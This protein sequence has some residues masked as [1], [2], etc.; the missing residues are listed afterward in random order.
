MYSF[1]CLLLLRCVDRVIGGDRGL[2]RHCKRAGHRRV[3]RLHPSTGVPLPLRTLRQR[4][5]DRYRV[6]M[7]CLSSRKSPHSGLPCTINCDLSHFSSP[8]VVWLAT[9][10]TLSPLPPWITW[11]SARSFP[12]FRW[13]LQMEWMSLSAGWFA[14]F[15]CFMYGFFNTGAVITDLADR[16]QFNQLFFVACF[17]CQTLKWKS[18]GKVTCALLFTAIK[19][20]ETAMTTTLR[21]SS[22]LF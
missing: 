21:R 11:K 20:T 13:W 17:Y 3:L 16:F 19:T 8:Q 7:R 18:F 10:I 4:H 2:S 22:G 1:K 15:P 14:L 6:S 9:S 5:G 12:L